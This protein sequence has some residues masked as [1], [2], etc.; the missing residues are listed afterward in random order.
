MYRPGLL[1][2]G[3]DRCSSPAGL[4]HPGRARRWHAVR[5]YLRRA[6]LH[7]AE[8][9]VRE[10]LQDGWR[11]ERVIAGVA[12]QGGQQ[13]QQ[14]YDGGE[15]GERGR[16]VRGSQRE[17]GDDMRRRECS[18]VGRRGEGRKAWT[19]D[20]DGEAG[21]V[22][23]GGGTGSVVCGDK[24]PDGLISDADRLARGGQ[25][26]PAAVAVSGTQGSPQA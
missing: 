21:E 6:E 15:A 16:G 4:H 24:M 17:G 25:K 20:G 5:C 23:D 12:E 18:D 26:L 22:T 8:R 14:L 7:V 10:L 3:R 11:E 9:G 19:G 1:G 13:L 2:P